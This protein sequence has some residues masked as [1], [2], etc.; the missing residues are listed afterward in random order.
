MGNSVFPAASTSSNVNY[1]I[2]S[3]AARPASPTSGYTR[4]NT[5]YNYFEIYD[6]T[7]WR[8]FTPAYGGGTAAPLSIEYLIGGAG[9]AGGG[10][11]RG[12]GAGGEIFTGQF[13]PGGNTYTVT[14]GA[15]ALWTTNGGRNGGSSSIAATG[16]TTV[17]ATAGQDGQDP[18]GGVGRNG[19][20]NGGNYPGGAAANGTLWIDGTG[21][22]GGGGGGNGGAGATTYGG[23][24]GG[25]S[26]QAGTTPGANRSGGG[27]G[28]GDGGGAG[29]GGSGVVIIRYPDVF[30]DLTSQSGA[31][32]TTTGG[33]KYY[34]FTGSGSFVV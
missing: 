11:G 8:I 9:G 20:G 3:T 6:G 28:A 4:Y 2:G 31:T 12:G 30:K 5:D 23:A 14:V 24:N 1:N 10:N 33:F 26:G 25:S 34:T 19:G 16:F 22:G 17:T 27:G 13:T 18:N 32:K 7:N 29:T 15:G 21:Y